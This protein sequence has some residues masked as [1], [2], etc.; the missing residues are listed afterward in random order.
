[1]KLRQWRHIVKLFAPYRVSIALFTVS[2]FAAAVFGLVMPYATGDIVDALIQHEPSRVAQLALISVAGMTLFAIAGFVRNHFAGVAI[3]RMAR[4]LSVRVF[5]TIQRAQLEF[6]TRTTTGEI[7][8]VI[9]GD[10]DHM[11]DILFDTIFPMVGS[12]I[13]IAMTVLSM[14]I[15]N[16]R[17]SLASFAVVP[18]W[19]WVMRF[20]TRACVPL[21]RELRARLDDN[22]SFVSE[23]LSLVAAIR[24]KAAVAYE[25]ERRQYEQVLNPYIGL[26][27]RIITV[28]GYGTIATTIV[29]SIGPALLMLI[30]AWLV[31]DHYSSVGTLTAF[32]ALQARLYGPVQSLVTASIQ[33]PRFATALGRVEDLLALPQERLGNEPAKHGSIE[34]R[35]ISVVSGDRAIL[36]GFCL[37]IDY[38]EHVGIMGPS[39]CGKTTLAHLLLALRSPD[40]GEVMLAGVTLSRLSIDSLRELI[41]YVPSDDSIFDGTILE[42]ATYGATEASPAD[43]REALDAV[44]LTSRIEDMPDGLNTRVGVAGMTLSS[45]ERQRLMLARALLR[46]RHV[47]LLDEATRGVD[48]DSERHIMTAIREQMKGRTLICITHRITALAG[49]DRIVTLGQESLDEDAR[50]T[51]ER[52]SLESVAKL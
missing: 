47:L 22:N 7:I 40:A 11:A 43:V 30:G 44:A 10:V 20:S 12:A 33:L 48:V 6:F 24:M 1:M 23:R 46:P 5:T 26:E 38:G 45:G 29:N 52:L 8:N 49:F 42:N 50:V 9:R 3:R 14:L 15:T 34:F 28:Y 18:L 19:I 51:Q 35:D 25:N 27:G 21:H 41:T 13:I 4:D 31:A 39:G 17:L 32:M 37:S 36:S 2:T 16:W